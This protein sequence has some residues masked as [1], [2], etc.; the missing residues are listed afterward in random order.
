MT[1]GFHE[2]FERSEEVKGSSNRVFG[3]VFAVVFGLVGLWPLLDG[4]DPRWWALFVSG[5][6]LLFALFLPRH[7]TPLNNLWTRFGLLLHRIVSPIVLGLI[8]AVAVTPVALILR[9]CG[10]DP[11]RRHFE[12]DARSYW[13]ERKDDAGPPPETMRNQF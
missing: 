7:L 2:D 10:K 12:P 8:F 4:A 11:L 6:F 9:L 1:K 5:G 3:L 13:I